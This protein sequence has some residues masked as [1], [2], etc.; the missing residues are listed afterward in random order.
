MTESVLNVVVGCFLIAFGAGVV[1]FRSHVARLNAQGQRGMWGK[2]AKYSAARSTP[3]NAAFV[4]CGSL[5][6][7][8]IALLMGVSGLFPG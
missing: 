1:V 7:G 2:F 6:L 4:G 8:A 5:V 3:A